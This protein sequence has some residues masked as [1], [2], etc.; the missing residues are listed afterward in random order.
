M[1]WIVLKYGG[2]SITV[3][4]FNNILQRIEVLKG[5]LN[6]VIV[7]SAIKNVTNCLINN[8]ILEAKKIYG[9]FMDKLNFDKLF[10][11]DMFNLLDHEITYKSKRKLVS[12]GE[13]LSTIIFNKYASQN[14]N[15]K[16]I[17]SKEFIK[18]KS[19]YKNDDDLFL[20]SEYYGDKDKFISLIE[21]N[22]I[23]ICQGFVGSTPKNDIC[24]IG[25]GGSDTSAAIIANM[26][27]AS[28][29]EIW[30]DVNGMYT[31][32]PY[33]IHNSKIINNIGYNQ[34]QELAAMGAKVLHPYCIIPCKVKNIPI[35]IKNTYDMN[36]MNYTT[37][38]KQDIRLN[39]IYAITDQ[40]NITVFTIESIN[41]WNNYGFV[42]D[43][44]E[45]FS[46]Y[47]IDVNI[48]STSQFT[49]ST[50]TDCTNLIQLNDVFNKLKEK[51]NV[52][53]KHNC[54]IISIVGDSIKNQEFLP[55]AITISRKFKNIHMIHHSANDMT[56][57]FVIDGC[58]SN[59]LL[60]ELH[61][62]LLD[63][64]IVNNDNHNIEKKWW[65]NK[66]EDVKQLMK[67]NNSIYLYNLQFIKDQINFLKSK[68]PIVKKIFYSMKANNNN[69][70]IK[71][72]SNQNIGF[73]CVSYNEVN[74]LR[75][76]LNINDDIIFTPNFCSISEYNK[77]L[78]MNNVIV[79]VDNIEIIKNNLE[80]FLNKEIGIR[81]DLNIGL[82]HHKNVITEGNKAKF[83]S[84][85]QDILDNIMFLNKS[86]FKI[87]GL[88]SHRGSGIHDYSSWYNTACSLINLS[89][90]FNNIKWINLGGGFGVDSNTPIDFNALNYSLS[91]IKSD[92]D[93]YIEPGRFIVSESGVLIS[94]VTQIKEKEL[95]NYIG[96]HTGMNSLIRPTLYG[97]YHK[98]HN[99]SKI[100]KKR[101]KIYNVVG[102]ICESGDI[103]GTNRLLP[104][105]E[106]DDIILIENG[107]AYGH[108]MSTAYNMREPAI[109]IELSP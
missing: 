94:K 2:S 98:I 67:D 85:I 21:N 5:R 28:C 6:I 4:G 53:K 79:I 42:Y 8:N 106:I 95:I 70:I 56:I 74:Y 14:Y 73:E 61:T 50:T 68:L 51:Y 9:D 99:I 35:L 20:S 93:F 77:C 72:I 27:D 65:Y 11:N 19:E 60:M 23:I 54:S 37:I 48:I 97:S 38:C 24:L 34:A 44:F 92:I 59:K 66:M 52:E 15:C 69:N 25:R 47:N 3:D 91:G 10:Q 83:G 57:S 29:L 7:L 32:D 96:L 30:T 49:I 46:Y 107:G 22:N 43:I 90:Y 36:N 84:P 31:A 41:M 78:N 88:H 1:N 109:E 100:N 63:V 33:K 58:E 64:D 103:L 55:D 82:G 102:P 16:L 17:K 87:V 80:L 39:K 89:K 108:V 101:N 45:K 81:V 105:T 62:C 71:T 86:G 40:H 104:N 18:S 26:L 12:L 76:K 75:N 13:M